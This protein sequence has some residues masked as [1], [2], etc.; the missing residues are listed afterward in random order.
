MTTQQIDDLVY[1]L[2]FDG[3]SEESQMENLGELIRSLPQPVLDQIEDE[4]S[5][6][7]MSS[8]SAQLFAKFGKKILVE[9][10]SLTKPQPIEQTKEQLFEETF[11]FSFNEVILNQPQ[12]SDGC[13]RYVHPHDSTQVFKYL[14]ANSL[15]NSS[16]RHKWQKC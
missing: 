13:I 5:S 9:I 15:Q 8:D 6:V 14:P 1:G 16:P 10:F 4:S 3:S 12:I 11:G 7:D 2:I